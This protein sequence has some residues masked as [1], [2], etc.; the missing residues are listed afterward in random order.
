MFDERVR[1]D[2]YA[3]EVRGRKE[4]LKVF[5]YGILHPVVENIPLSSFSTV[6]KTKTG[7]SGA[8]TQWMTRPHV[9]ICS[10]HQ[11]ISKFISSGAIA[12]EMHYVS[13]W[14]RMLDHPDMVRRRGL[15]NLYDQPLGRHNEAVVVHQVKTEKLWQ[16][17]NEWL[18]LTR[19][20]IDV[21]HVRRMSPRQR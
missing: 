3:L 2:A 7:P 14:Y 19:N 5:L 20:G 15:S 10:L 21:C 11:V 1:D 16:K 6:P 17:V 4:V 13:D 9:L 18:D 12:D 8:S